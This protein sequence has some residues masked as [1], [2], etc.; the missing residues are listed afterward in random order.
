MESLVL[1]GSKRCFVRFPRFYQEFENV[2]SF[3]FRTKRLNGLL[4][5]SDDGG[6]SN[7]FE[8]RLFDGQIHLQF[9]L[10]SNSSQKDPAGIM[11]LGKDLNDNR[12]HKVALYQFYD[13]LKLEIDATMEMRTLLQKD[14]I[15]GKYE[16]RSEV[17]VGG[18]PPSMPISKLSYKLVKQT[19]HFQVSKF[20]LFF[21]SSSSSSSLLAEV[22]LVAALLGIREECCLSHL[23]PRCDRPSHFGLRWHSGV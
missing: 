22:S 10:G 21:S 7:F 14:Y 2:I 20:L 23:S 19:D 9:R 1:D 15:F 13:K 3:E 17:F 18:I 6:T 12:W 5:Y 8:I 11:V 16:T 4:F